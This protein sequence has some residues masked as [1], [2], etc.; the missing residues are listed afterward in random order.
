MKKRFITLVMLGVMAVS[1]L[2]ACGNKDDEGRT[3]NKA[4]AKR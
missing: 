4:A 1:T 2:T 3:R